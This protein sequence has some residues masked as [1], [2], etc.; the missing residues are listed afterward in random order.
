MDWYDDSI[1]EVLKELTKSKLQDSPSLADKCI[2]LISN[3]LLVIA[4]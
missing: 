4:I 2:F 3:A 1:K